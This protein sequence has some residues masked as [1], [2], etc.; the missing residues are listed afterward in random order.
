MR[1]LLAADNIDTPSA[2][3]PKGRLRNK[4]GGDGTTVSEV[5]MGDFVQFFQKLIGD[6][7]ITENGLP[8]NTT[9]GF[10]LVQAVDLRYYKKKE[11]V[12]TWD[13]VVD[14]DISVAHGLD[15][16]KIKT[17]NGYII[18]GNSLKQPFPMVGDGS[19]VVNA[20]IFS[21]DA[22]NINLKKLNSNY[23]EEFYLNSSVVLTVEY[24]D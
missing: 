5:W 3:Y 2:D 22:T 13:M 1:A 20:V 16:T 23:N 10:Q 12:T 9:N 8:D 11:I 24:I 6:A 18:N 19:V 14:S 7:G 4:N 21:T 17:I 15:N